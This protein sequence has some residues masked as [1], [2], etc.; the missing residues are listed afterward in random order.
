[1]LLRAKPTRHRLPLVVLL[2]ASLLGCGGGHDDP[3][4][5]ATLREANDTLA[6]ES[7][8]SATIKVATS[9]LTT[10]SPDVLVLEGGT[11]LPMGEEPQPTQEHSATADATPWL[12]QGPCTQGTGALTDSTL[13]AA[14][15]H[16]IVTGRTYYVAT[17]GSDAWP[18]TAQMPLASPQRAIDLTA[19]G[20]TVILRAGTYFISKA[21]QIEGKAGFPGAPITVRGET[22]VVLR[23]TDVSVPGIW[24]GLIEVERSTSI[25]IRNIAVENSGFFGFRIRNSQDVTLD[26]NQS[27]VSLGSAIY[28]ESS[29]N[30][31]IINND[32]SRFCDKGQFG[33]DGRT[34]CQEGISLAGVDGF[35]VYGNQVHDAM[36]TAGVRPGGGEGID[37][38]QGSRN[39][40]IAFNSV[41]NLVQLGIYVDAY[42]AGVSKIDIYGNRVW[43]TNAGIVVSSE[44]GGVASDIRVHHNIVHDVGSD[45]ILISDFTSRSKPGGDGLRQFIRI[46]NNTVVNAGL[47]EAKT[48]FHYPA[49]AS[50]P[51]VDW[52]SGIRVSTT[53]VVGLQVIDNI[54][55]GSKTSPMRIPG[56]LRASAQ[57]QNNLQWPLP[58]SRSADEYVGLAP[59]LADPQFRSLLGNDW[60]LSATSPAIGRGSGLGHPALV[61]ASG[62]VL[63]GPSQDLGALAFQP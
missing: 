41:W 60:R 30:I 15:S 56:S 18:G 52:G 37:A 34:G 51:A 8:P 3:E 4:A 11:K 5:A 40:I 7:A 54:I 53:N 48:S 27:T 14:Q 36:Q 43:R 21:I 29:R 35:A 26:T 63:D 45:G 31:S 2:I 50:S 44:A 57:I 6:D 47:R 28:A 49:S 12:D 20:D 61:D 55:Y 22:G 58:R 9:A 19:P 32:V 39:G 62:E 59:V 46:A 16:K 1:M 23:A 33:A 38:K 13:C 17:H 24:R 10:E 42:T 25:R